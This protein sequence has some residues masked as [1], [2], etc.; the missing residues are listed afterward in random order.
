[1]KESET[2]SEGLDLESAA[3]RVADCTCAQA[4][5]ADAWDV[6]ICRSLI[7]QLWSLR[8]DM[9]QYEQTLAPRLTGV[10]PAYRES[11]RNLAHYLA[12]RRE[13]RRPLQE[14]LAWMGLSSLGRS[15]SHV[16][17]NLDKVLGILHRLTG[18]PWTDR[19]SEEP[20]GINGSRERIEGHAAD[21][22]GAPP[23][24]RD[25]RIMVTLPSQAANDEALVRQLVAAGMDIARINCAHDGA[26]DWQAMAAHVRHAAEEAG[27]SVRILM[28]LGGPKLRTGPIAPGPAVLKLRPTRDALGQVVATAKIGLRSAGS[29][30]AVAGASA[31]LGVEEGW[32][33]R[34][35]AGDE[36]RLT[37]ARDA[38]RKLRVIGLDEAGVLAECDQTVYVVP[39]TWL[40]LKR[41]GRYKHGTAV[42][43]VPHKPGRILLRKGDRL[44]VTRGDTGLPGGNG[45]ESGG[46]TLPSVPCT[47]PEVFAQVQAGE[48][49]WFD[50]GHIGAVIREVGLDGLVV[51]VTQAPPSGAQLAEDKGINLP[52]SRLSLPALTAKDL[53]DLATVARCADMV[54]LSFV[55]ARGDVEALLARLSELGAA[56]LGLVLKIETRRAFENLPELMLGAMASRT[57]GIMIARGDLAVECGYERL[58]EVQ[59]EMLWA[60]EA[61]HMPVVWATQVLETLAKTGVPSRAEITDAA[62]GERAECVMLN[63][64]PH[65]VD[66]MRT[67]DDILRR[68]QAHQKKKRSLLRALGAWS[69]PAPEHH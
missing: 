66:A 24:G 57:A 68:M 29:T 40:A 36:I 17:A 56:D 21:L 69:G 34:L 8:R 30:L 64:G 65:I 22:L 54:G 15:E 12:L 48:R 47:L 62:M 32:L 50:D 37:D 63:K 58:A 52:D 10:S 31:H 5:S 14:K 26:P 39:Q 19:S 13:D 45:A 27:R 42:A 61:A 1:M 46:D 7:D 3:E 41:H 44:R 9:L 60:A 43:D 59:E 2:Q 16:L 6:E 33:A 55:H 11:A 35:K 67:L 25:V 53:A 23:P 38:K 49:I 20:A 28:D 51:E 4:A 18:Q